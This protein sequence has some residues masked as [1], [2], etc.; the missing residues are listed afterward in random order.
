MTALPDVA[1]A[2]RIGPHPQGET[3]VTAS[4]LDGACVWETRPT[5]D[6]QAANVACLAH[7]VATGHGTFAVTVEYVALVSG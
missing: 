1:V 3:T 2:H 5:A 7:A 6:P 4:C